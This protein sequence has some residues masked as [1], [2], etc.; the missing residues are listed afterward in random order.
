M[1]STRFQMGLISS[2]NLRMDSSL[3]VNPGTITWRTQ[4]CP[5]S[6]SPPDP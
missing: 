4:I 5:E 1:R 3:S 6:R 2:M